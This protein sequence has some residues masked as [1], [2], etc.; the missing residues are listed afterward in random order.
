MKKKKKDCVKLKWFQNTELANT[1]CVRGLI[2]TTKRPYL[3]R[4]AGKYNDNCRAESP[5]QRAFPPLTR[6]SGVT[7][8]TRGKREWLPNSVV[9][10]LCVQR[11]NKKKWSLQIL[12]CFLRRLWRNAQKR[13]IFRGW[14]YISMW[15]TYGF[16]WF[17]FRGKQAE[18]HAQKK[19]KKSHTGNGLDIMHTM[20]LFKPQ[21]KQ[22]WTAG[23][24]RKVVET[25]MESGWIPN[26][27]ITKSL[28]SINTKSM[29]KRGGEGLFF[30]KKKKGR[31]SQNAHR[32]PSLPV[33]G[34]CCHGISPRRISSVWAAERLA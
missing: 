22:S 24:S 32:S 14:V 9:S 2:H 1:Q 25:A 30:L 12:E 3:W 4:P 6:C 19:K 11:T 31:G 29:T 23:C 10:W 20:S 33:G 27:W 28:P 5:L 34:V 16:P 18:Q 21:T 26:A 8:S 7:W 15:H 17:Q 13:W